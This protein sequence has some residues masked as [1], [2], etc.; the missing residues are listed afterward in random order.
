MHIFCDAGKDAYTVCIFLRV[1]VSSIT[2]ARLLQAKSRVASTKKMSI[3]HLELLA[4][5]IAARLYDSTR[6]FFDKE[7]TCFFWSDSTTVLC[8]IKRTEEWSIF[9]ENRIREIRSLTRQDN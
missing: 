9:V 2:Y 6:R 3:P 1:V 5:T 7:L 4:A 8:W